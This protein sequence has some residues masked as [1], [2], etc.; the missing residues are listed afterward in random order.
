MLGFW[1]DP[2]MSFK[3]SLL[4]ASSSNQQLQ[5]QPIQPF[6]AATNNVNTAQQPDPIAVAA[7]T[8]TMQQQ[9]QHGFEELKAEVKQELIGKTALSTI[10]TN[11]TDASESAAKNNGLRD[12][13]MMDVAELEKERGD[14]NE[15]DN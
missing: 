10:Q 4:A 6:Q 8:G 11:Q 13:D 9:I 1:N 2:Q 5:Q 7:T 3:L 12:V 14:P 15:R